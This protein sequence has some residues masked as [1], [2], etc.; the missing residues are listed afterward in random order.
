MIYAVSIVTVQHSYSFA[1]A[2]QIAADLFESKAEKRSL[3]L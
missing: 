1:I 3:L 2:V